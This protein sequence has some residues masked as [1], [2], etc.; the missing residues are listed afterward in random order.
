M[1][2]NDAAEALDNLSLSLKEPNLSNTNMASEGRT[3][4]GA[5]GA[6]D[7]SINSGEYEAPQAG[8]QGNQDAGSTVD[9]GMVGATP[10]RV[11]GNA[12]MSP[13]V[14]VATM[15]TS[16]LCNWLE[17]AGAEQA[18]LEFVQQGRMTG[19]EFVYGLDEKNRGSSVV[20]TLLDEM[21]ISRC[22]I[23]LRCVA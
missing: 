2:D 20:Q 18:T 6:D 4:S 3:I 23:R 15:G 22:M 10:T 9:S 8:A 21:H 17:S 19:K 16:G 7:A 1:R 12:P 13:D 5:A 11:I 14:P